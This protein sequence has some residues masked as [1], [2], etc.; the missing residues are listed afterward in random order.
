MGYGFY[1]RLKLYHNEMI[2]QYQVQLQ[3]I[4]DKKSNL[5]NISSAIMDGEITPEERLNDPMNALSY[6]A[7]EQN[8]NAFVES[9]EAGKL[10]MEGVANYLTQQGQ[11]QT[12]EQSDAIFNSLRRSLAM[13]YATKIAAK[14]LEAEEHKLDME[15]TKIETKLNAEMRQLE[16]VERAEAQAVERSAPKFS[17]LG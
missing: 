2:Y 7:F 16:A 15:K 14:K 4:M 17:G 13:E 12:Q 5:I 6:N 1:T 11:E 8:R 9:N 3:Q 10:T